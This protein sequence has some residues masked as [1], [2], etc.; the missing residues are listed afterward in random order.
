MK[1]YLIGEYNTVTTYRAFHSEIKAMLT[2]REIYEG[3]CE[4]EQLETE[5]EDFLNEFDGPYCF[6]EIVTV[7]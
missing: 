2:A 1:V 4:P 5:W 6:F 7:E 3:C